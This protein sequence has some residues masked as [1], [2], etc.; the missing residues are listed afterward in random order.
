MAVAGAEWS[1]AI[2]GVEKV[3]PVDIEKLTEKYLGRPKFNGFAASAEVKDVILERE[4]ALFEKFPGKLKAGARQREGS[5]IEAL[6]LLF[7]GRA[8]AGPADTW[9]WGG[10]ALHIVLENSKG[11]KRLEEDLASLGARIQWGDNPYIPMDDYL[12]NP[13]WAFLRL[14]A[15]ACSM[16]NAAALLA[17]FM[18][19]YEITADDVAIAA[20]ALAREY[21]MRSKQSS[22]ALKN[23]VYPKLFAGHPWGLPLIPAPGH[24]AGIDAEVLGGIRKQLHRSSGSVVTIVSPST[25]EE[26][27]ALLRRM[28][29][30]YRTD[31]NAVCPDLVP[32]REVRLMEG[33]SPG[34]GLQLAVSWRIDGMTNKMFAAMAVAAEALSRRMQLDIR[35]TRGLAY[36]TGCSM[37]RVSS[38]A[39][40]TA[41][42]GTRPGNSE[43]A[44][45]ALEEVVRGIE[46]DPLTP[47][48]TAAARSRLVSR[49]SRRELSSAGEALGMALDGLYRGGIDG[50]ALISSVHPDEVAAM[51]DRLAWDS[52]LITRLLP[53]EKAPE[54]K[55][56]PPG[57]MGR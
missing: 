40:V 57:M 38:R 37:T 9:G 14:E 51:A 10:S 15:P 31:G 39:V 42:L 53:G 23:A 13:H 4:E 27:M 36:S 5:P 21:S 1:R 49:L 55:S 16:E 32:A 45:T 6:C 52:A 18:E 35:E 8:C 17:A 25:R 11:G 50:L 44:E 20:P 28:F 56:M 46:V 3:K 41:R 43:E 29:G 24:S 22:P 30:E 7:P 26:S 48:E 47:A 54:K 12:V 33:E 2:A 34:S 19:D